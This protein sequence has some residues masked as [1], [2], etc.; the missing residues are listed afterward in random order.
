M[1]S[2]VVVYSVLIVVVE[3]VQAAIERM[4][5]N[6]MTVWHYI[7]ELRIWYVVRR[8]LAIVRYLTARDCHG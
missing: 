3:D 8:C 7:A 2:E 1:N 6:T 5:E 4:L